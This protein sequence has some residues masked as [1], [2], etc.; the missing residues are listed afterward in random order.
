MKRTVPQ[1]TQKVY[2]VAVIGGG[3]YGISL[4]RDAA[5]R[6][7]SVAL[8]DQGDFG[9]AT[10]SN[11]H[12]IIHGGL[13]YLQHANLK[14]MR[15]SI[16]ERS[17]LMRIA[18]HLVYPIP[19][20]VPTYKNVLQGKLVMSVA[21]KLNDL[22][23]F[24][25]NQNLEPHKRIPRGRILSKAECLQFC[26]GLD[27]RD[28]TGG[29]LFFDGQVYNPDRLNLSLLLSASA[30]GA[31]LVN[32]V[33]VTEFLQE[34]NSIRGVKVRDIFSKEFF[35]LRARFVVNCSGPWMDSVLQ[36]LGPTGQR[37]RFDL[38]KAAVL[39]TRPLVQ[40]TAV[41]I[42]S[43]SQYR[44]L[45]AIINKGQ[46]LFFIVPWRDASLVGT[47]QAPYNGT[48]DSFKITEQNISDFICEVNAAFPGAALKRQ[49]VRFVYSGLLPGVDTGSRDESVQLVKQYGIHDHAIGD[50]IQGL[51]SVA[52][53]KY[54]MARSVAEK[55]VNLVEQ[56]LG[57]KPV[58]CLTSAIPVH[59]GVIDRFEEFVDRALSKTPRGI[60]KET[61]RHLLQTY[62]SKYQEILQYCDDNPIWSQPASID[63]PVIN[64]EVLHGCRVE[65]AQK[66]S[67]V[68]FRR[69]ELGTAGHPGD[70]CIENCAAIM[71]KEMGW[72]KKRMTREIEEVQLSF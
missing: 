41:G 5:L 24:D 64:A 43:R 35:D 8:V 38:I 72:D 56:K 66:L 59:G 20:L 37:K 40:Q 3:I 26:P 31:D 52:G 58:K 39:V 57:R 50:R 44:D 51:I 34:R 12:K 42:P 47:F 53:V 45:H 48:P 18:P 27:Q 11:N 71:A 62:G 33:Q 15:E 67:D 22:I 68:I 32:Y 36:L 60:G 10:S 13:R 14:R 69:T 1:L 9:S 46:R 29:A 23:S 6:G 55:A 25:R 17:I 61:Q 65:M 19:F 4:T 7:L 54:T 30:A 28:L 2:D 63:S 16:R 21:L 70:S 49:D